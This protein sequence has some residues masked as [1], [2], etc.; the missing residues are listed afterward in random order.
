MAS[1]GLSPDVLVSAFFLSGNGAQRPDHLFSA[2]VEDAN[3][4]CR[5][6]DDDSKVSVPVPE[7]AE[8]AEKMD[9]VVD[10]VVSKL[11]FIGDE[12]EA[13]AKGNA[14]QKR[15]AYDTIF[16]EGYDSDG[17]IEYNTFIRAVEIIK[18]CIFEPC[19]FKSDKEAKQA[20]VGTFLTFSKS[21]FVQSGQHYHKDRVANVFR[22][23]VQEHA[24]KYMRTA[25]PTVSSALDMGS[26]V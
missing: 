10:C 26:E 8:E 11:K 6:L 4:I 3:M 12:V 24:S 23:R 9:R 13:K 14:K 17:N 5:G 22:M 16:A 20:W 7:T 18:K 15:D 2:A 19:S 1:T 21:L 25:W